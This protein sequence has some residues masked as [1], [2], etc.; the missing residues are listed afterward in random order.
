MTDEI[1]SLL[2]FSKQREKIRPVFGR[3]NDVI[4]RAIQTVRVLPEFE[5]IA[6][7]FT[8]GDDCA[9]SFDPAKV[10]RAVVNLLF[11]ACE[12]V[13]RDGGRVELSCH[14]NAQGLEIRIS[15]NGPGIPESIREN[16]FQPFVSFGKAKGIGLGLTV[17]RKIMQDHGGDVQVEK[18]GPQGTVFVLSLPSSVPEQVPAAV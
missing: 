7:V 6:I 17:V 18:T 9:A 16:L 11:N 1:N 3:L 14:R 10:E 5:S 2:G 4:E 12:V 15:D 8:P 13:P